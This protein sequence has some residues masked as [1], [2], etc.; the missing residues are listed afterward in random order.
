MIGLYD[1]SEQDGKVVQYIEAL[2]KKES[3]KNVAHK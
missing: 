1:S 3:F 2:Q